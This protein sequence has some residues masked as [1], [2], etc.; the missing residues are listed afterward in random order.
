MTISSL[1][2]LLLVFLFVH[3]LDMGFLGICIATCL[4]FVSR[5]IIVVI[6]IETI[7][8]LKNNY[9]VELF[10]EESRKNISHQFNLGLHSLS[11][12]VW[13]WWAFDI[14][15]LIASY[16]SVEEVSA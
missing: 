15:T 12:G 7:G 14:F 10:S 6:Q 11:M 9:G 16:L 1:I 8:A 13:G 2:H 3:M 4:M 5:L